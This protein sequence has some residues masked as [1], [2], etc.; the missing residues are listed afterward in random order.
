MDPTDLSGQVEFVRERWS[1][2]AAAMGSR[3]AVRE[4]LERVRATRARTRLG[5][6]ISNE[7]DR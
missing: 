3:P 1:D 4:C 6:S 5:L 2:I 7:D